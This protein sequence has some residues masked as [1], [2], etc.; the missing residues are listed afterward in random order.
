MKVLALHFSF[1][2][3]P[4]APQIYR[5]NMPLW[6]LGQHPGWT[7]EVEQ[8][9]NIVQSYLQYGSQVFID[10]ARSYDLFIFPR[11]TVPIGATLETIS[12]LFDLLHLY[13][14]HIVYE[15][16]D[17]FTNQHRDIGATD[18][19]TLASWCD[20]VTVTTPYL[21]DLM[22]RETRRP[23]HVIPNMLHPDV[24]R[25]PENSLP[26][27]GIIIGLSGSPT[28]GK[29]WKVMETVLPRI[30]EENPTARLRVTGYHPEYLQG[31][32][33]TEY[34]PP[35]DYVTYAEVVRSCDIILAPIDPNDPF[36]NSKSPIKVVEGGGASRP[37]GDSI[38][39]AACIAT[40][41]LVYRLA[42]NSGE[43]GL[44][45][46]HTPEGWY[47]GLTRLLQD[48]ALRTRLQHK[49][50]HSVWKRLDLTT[51]WTLWARAYQKIV[52]R[53]IH[54]HNKHLAKALR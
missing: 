27:E 8:W 5:A 24:W 29:D 37:V 28:H 25:K 30:L 18:A 51:Y 34:L 50:H 7:T 41:H 43:N 14:K 15:V 53:P 19:M 40:D 23:V 35:V 48:E 32:P 54:H 46:E 3:Q 20:A 26:H 6:V 4:T 17:D 31:L 11:L 36:N 22:R 44:L 1:D 21:G 47:Q 38:G 12:P 2:T 13:G 42:I 9:G 33:N 10:L 16:D 52:S 39:G 45:V 49:M